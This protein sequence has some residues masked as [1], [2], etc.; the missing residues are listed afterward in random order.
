M[1]TEV[2]KVFRQKTPTATESSS[3]RLAAYNWDHP[4]PGHGSSMDSV[5]FFSKRRSRRG[6][7]LGRIHSDKLICRLFLRTIATLNHTLSLTSIHPSSLFCCYW[8][9]PDGYGLAVD[10]Y[11]VLFVGPIDPPT[12]CLSLKSRSKPW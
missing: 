10:L 9:L 3:W 8:L 12:T 7:T 2:S 11:K 5:E 1:V 6:Q 4:S